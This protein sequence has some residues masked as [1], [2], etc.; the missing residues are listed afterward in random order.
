LFLS[1][2]DVKAAINLVREGVIDVTDLK[3]NEVI[4]KRRLFIITRKFRDF[5]HLVERRRRR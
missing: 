4:K 3:V 1:D 5:R 2:K